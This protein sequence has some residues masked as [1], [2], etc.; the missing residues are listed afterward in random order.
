MPER[1][2]GDTPQQDPAPS[3]SARKRQMHALQALGESLLALNDRQL[4]RIPVQDEQLLQ[5]ILPQAET[6]GQLSA[7]DYEAAENKLGRLFRRYP[8]QPA[9]TCTYLAILAMDVHRLRGDLMRHVIF[10]GGGDHAAGYTA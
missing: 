3:K 8:S 5:A 2:R 4:S 10:R 1:Q 7:A 6:T 9:G